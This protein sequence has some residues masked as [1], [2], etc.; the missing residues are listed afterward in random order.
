LIGFR[1]AIY[2][3]KNLGSDVLPIFFSYLHKNRLILS[4][5]RQNFSTPIFSN[6]KQKIF[7]KYRLF[8]ITFS[9]GVDTSLAYR[10]YDK[11]NVNL[12]LLV[13]SKTLRFLYYFEKSKNKINYFLDYFPFLLY[14]DFEK[15]IFDTFPILKLVKGELEEH[16]PNIKILL[17][18]SGA[19]LC[20]IIEKNKIVFD[21]EKFKKILSSFNEIGK[22]FYL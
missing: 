6:L 11:K 9:F 4:L 13:G 1:E 22:I 2:L 15:V 21:E 7:H 8:L 19:S 18:G 3:A 5:E 10:E 12:D 20:G 17:C 14:N 16:F